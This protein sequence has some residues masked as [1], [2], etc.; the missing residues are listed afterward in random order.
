[1][2]IPTSQQAYDELIRS[3]G[4]AIGHPRVGGDVHAAVLGAAVQIESVG[5]LR[6]SMASLERAMGDFT[7]ASRSGSEALTKVTNRLVIAT[8][9]LAGVAAVQ[10]V[11]FVVQVF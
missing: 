8:W 11:A 4:G 2:P 6:D 10:A 9:I 7:D 3:V 1:M 5:G